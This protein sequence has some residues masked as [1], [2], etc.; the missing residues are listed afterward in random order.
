MNPAAVFVLLVVALIVG[1]SILV[2]ANGIVGYL[3]HR[4]KVNKGTVDRAVTTR[5]E[6]MRALADIEELCRAAAYAPSLDVYRLTLQ[7]IEGRIDQARNNIANKE[8][9]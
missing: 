8:I 6:A 2:A 5:R 4:D 1:G 7:E 3:Q 9:A